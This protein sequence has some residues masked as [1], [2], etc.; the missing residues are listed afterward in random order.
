[1]LKILDLVTSSAYFVYI[2]RIIHNITVATFFG[3]RLTLFFMIV[4]RF[5]IKIFF[6]QQTA[7]IKTFKF[8]V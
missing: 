7:M 6:K 8:S 5:E 1:M 3:H 4:S 2:H